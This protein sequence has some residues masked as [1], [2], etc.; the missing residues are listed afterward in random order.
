VSRSR[1]VIRAT[2]S[3]RGSSIIVHAALVSTWMDSLDT[4][5]KHSDKA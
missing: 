2:L 5:T 1:L 3:R 4:K